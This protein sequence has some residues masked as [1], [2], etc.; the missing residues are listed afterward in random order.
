MGSR[1]F[2]DRNDFGNVPSNKTVIIQ[3]SIISII[4]Y[5]SNTLTIDID[6]CN[7]INNELF[8][9][10]KRDQATCNTIAG[11]PIRFPAK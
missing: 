6:N 11:T 8:H 4:S 10:R 3:S 1:K 7:S 5:D 2:T 9:V